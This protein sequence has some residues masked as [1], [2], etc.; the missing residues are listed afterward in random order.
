MS[1]SADVGDNLNGWLI[2]FIGY[3]KENAVPADYGG[4]LVE[5][6]N[7]L[8]A[9]LMKQDSVLKS[10]QNSTGMLK[11]TAGGGCFFTVFSHKEYLDGYKRKVLHRLL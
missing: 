3:G 8:E 1:V 5:R 9:H 7:Y 10:V 2:N 4:S 6:M 11:S